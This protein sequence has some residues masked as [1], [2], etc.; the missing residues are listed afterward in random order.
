M[1]CTPAIAPVPEVVVETV[2]VEA[3]A[4]PIEPTVEP[5]PEPFKLTWWTEYGTICCTDTI[6]WLVAEGIEEAGDLAYWYI[7]KFH[8]EYPQWAHVEIEPIFAM[9]IGGAFGPELDTM[10]AAGMTPDIIEGYGGRTGPYAVIGINHDEYLSEEQKADYIDY[11]SLF[12]GGEHI[13]LLPW[14]G[15][16]LYFTANPDL[17]ERAGLEAPDPW[18]SLSWDEYLAIG[19]GVKALDDGSYLSCL[20]AI[21]PMGQ[22]LMWSF[23]GGA[24]AALFEGGDYTKITLNTPATQGM[25]AEFVRM[26]DEGLIPSGVSG[27]SDDDCL[28]LWARGKLAI[29]PFHLGYTYVIADLVKSGVLEEVWE[30]IPILP[31]QFSD[32]ILPR[33]NGGPAI[34]T[35]MVPITTPEEKRAAAIDF[36]FFMGSRPDCLHATGIL[37]ARL[38]QLESEMGTPNEQIV[39]DHIIA[40]GLAD[41]GGLSPHYNEL[42]QLFA[43]LV[44]ATFLG[45]TTPD[46]ALSD[47][48]QLGNEI[49]TE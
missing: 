49:L 37:P 28:D 32:D 8:E 25:L 34:W 27:L 41:G 11:D 5:G 39:V 12:M 21:G 43:D 44:A 30:P 13:P 31:P 16:Y 22:Q 24:G 38:S 10:I 1:A 3:T 9:S 6:D 46:Q 26:R 7:G 42:R 17:I 36:A 14:F 33:V 19:E 2:V 15:N 23:Y 29:E 18:T 47:F 40:T 4:I 35:S 20:W 45:T 48:E